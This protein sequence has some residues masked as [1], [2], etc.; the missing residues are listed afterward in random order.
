MSDVTRYDKMATSLSLEDTK[1][2]YDIATVSYMAVKPNYLLLA[3]FKYMPK[4]HI[5]TTSLGSTQIRLENDAWKYEVAAGYKYY[6]TPSLYI[7]PALLFS[8]YYSTLY[9]VAGST[10]SE[11]ESHDIDFRFYGILGYKLAKATSFL[12]SIELD[13]D[14]LSN[15][16]S[17]DY[18]QYPFSITMFQFLSKEWFAYIKYQQAIKDKKERADSIG[19]SDSIAYG[20]GIGMKF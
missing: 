15:D 13:N 3:S 7:G 20:F 17:D 19:N 5:G 14:V 6:L 11:S 1:V 9:K 18:S 16:Y 12:V 8:D 10:V 4:Q 2:S